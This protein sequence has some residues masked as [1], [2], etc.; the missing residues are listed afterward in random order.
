MNPRRLRRELERAAPEDSAARERSWRVVQAAYADYEPRRRRRPWAALLAA[1]VAAVVGVAGVAA[2]S[3]PR[4]DVGRFV[5]HVLGVGEPGARPAL[6]RVPGGGRLLVTAGPSAW[7]VADDGARRRLGTYDGASWSPHG[8]FAA[9]W[10]DGELT[11]VDPHGRVRWTLPRRFV[12]Q[13]RWAPGDGFLVAYL[14]NGSLRIVGGDGTADHRFAAARSDIAPAW[15]PGAEHVLAYVDRRGRVDVA[16][17][18]SGRRVW[19]SAPVAQPAQL[20]WSAAGDRLLV[21][22]PRRL[23]LFGATGRL[24]AVRDVPAG[25]D[26]EHAVWSPRG[27]EIAVVRTSRAS[28][29]SEVVVLDARRG[30][31]E[32]LLPAGPGR[33]GAPAW[34][35]DGRWL[36]LPWPEADQ[37]LFLRPTGARRVLA[38]ANIA[39]QFTPGGGRGD[40][41]RSVTWCCPQAGR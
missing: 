31:R 40:F 12:T 9:V 38:V 11:A 20:L 24:L 8:L 5:R 15:R 17:A 25:A 33:F 28:R 1:A 21:L 39:R 7:V 22:T 2:A 23:S 19:R 13:A 32:R 34:S 37:W 4:S 14:S 30:L 3:A 10:R 35:P 6:V 36:L 27:H 16:S 41:P 29:R 18:D 26:A